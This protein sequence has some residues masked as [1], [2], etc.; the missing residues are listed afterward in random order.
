MFGGTNDWLV[1]TEDLDGWGAHTTAP[2]RI[3]VLPGDHFFLKTAEDTLLHAVSERL[4]G[5]R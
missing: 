5:I 1:P 4:A 2:F 3:D